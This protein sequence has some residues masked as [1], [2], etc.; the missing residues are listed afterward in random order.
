MATIFAKEVAKQNY[1]LILNSAWPSLKNNDRCIIGCICD[2]KNQLCLLKEEEDTW[3]LEKI[4][5]K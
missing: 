4:T 1:K 5:P 3:S 2:W